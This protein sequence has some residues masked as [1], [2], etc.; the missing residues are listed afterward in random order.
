[1][2]KWENTNHDAFVDHVFFNDVP[3]GMKK[4]KIVFTVE[5]ESYIY[6]TGK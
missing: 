6:V 5:K 4:L 2:Q 1:V 3:S